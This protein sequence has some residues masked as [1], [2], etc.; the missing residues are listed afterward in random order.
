MQNPIGEAD[1]EW[2]LHRNCEGTEQLQYVKIQ[3]YTIQKSTIKEDWVDNKILFR[4][5][6][7]EWIVTMFH[8]KHS[9]TVE[10]YEEITAYMF[11]VEH[12]GNKS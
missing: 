4:W 5:K 8:V 12:S 6:Q 7:K 10:F 2:I 3:R 11:H 9:K 1:S